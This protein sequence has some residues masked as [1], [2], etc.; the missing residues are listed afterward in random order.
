MS[1]LLLAVL[2]VAPPADARARLDRAV[3]LLGLRAAADALAVLDPLRAEAESAGES[4]VLMEAEHHTASAWRQRGDYPRALEADRR[5]LAL[6]RSGGDRSFE[7]R[8]LRNLAVTSKSKGDYAEGLAFAEEALAIHQALGEAEAAGRASMTLGALHDLRGEYPLALQ[9]YDEAEQALRASGGRDYSTLLGEAAI[10]YKNLGRYDEALARYE[11]ALEGHRQRGDRYGEMSTLSNVGN[12]YSLLGDFARAIDHYERA[13]ALA[14]EAG[15]RRGESF[16]LG[17]LGSVLLETDDAARA[18]PYLRQSLE[19][20]RAIGNRNGEAVALVN[21]GHAAAALDDLAGARERYAEA[22]AI[23]RGIGARA[24]AGSVLVAQAEVSLRAGDREAAAREAA[25]ALEAA[26]ETGNPELEWKAQQLLA[27]VARMEGRAEDAL[28]LLR[29]GMETISSI[30]GRIRTDAGKIGFLE[31]RQAVFHDAV[32]LLVAGGRHREALEAVEAAR[33][34]ALV[35][36]LAERRIAAAPADAEAV[37][38]IREDEVRLRAQA[39]AQPAGDEGM[40][41]LSR[42][43]AATLSSIG[44]RLDALRSTQPELASLVAADPPTFAQM[45]ATARRL[46]ATVVEYFVTEDRVFIFVLD[47][48]G[49][50]AAR[51]VGVERTRLRDS[52][53]AVHRMLNELDAEGLRDQAALHRALAG[54]HR[55][56]VAPVAALLPRDPGALVYVVPHDA[57]WRVPFAALRDARGRTL[58]RRHTLAFAPSLDVLRYTPGKG[59]A[60]TTPLLA[61]AD[62]R[63]G[64]DA[65][66]GAR[67]EV[68]QLARHFPADR[69]TVLVGADASEANGKRLAP[70]QGVL[71]F[72]VHGVIDDARPLDSALL[73]AS[74]EGEDGALHVAEAFGLRLQADLVVLSGCSTGLGKV[75]GDGVLGLARAFLYAGTPSVVVSQWDVSDRA[76]AYLM[77]RFYARL[78]AGRGKARALRAAQIATQAR[79]PHPAL[80]AAFSLVGEP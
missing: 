25:E 9:R 63:A 62:P 67:A 38:A 76:T 26:R 10:T 60:G 43:R 2:L 51:T 52:V 46:E 22:L 1:F 6:A 19:L 78:R 80:W 3:E 39:R 50:L 68:R 75:T 36:L 35:D 55:Q 77:D 8:I 54:L 37:A 65:L 53:G 29:A 17:N 18:L 7:A 58:L 73:L 23:Q 57:L 44:F 24:F 15:E 40:A 45:T 56:L 28:R 14:R 41:E 42:T 13:L 70:G 72:A 71:H 31:T 49:S 4:T 69:R 61:L 12:V 5:A 74:G 32:D 11:R 47:P 64:G 33:S 79:Y 21:L 16:L 27:R 48:R 34:R 30:R 66:P 20:T 59:A